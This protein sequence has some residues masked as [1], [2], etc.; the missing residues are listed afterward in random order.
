MFVGTTFEYMFRE[1]PNF[2]G[3]IE[4]WDVSS[5]VQMNHMFMDCPNFAQDLRLWEVGRVT[6][7][8]HMFVYVSLPKC[9]S[10]ATLILFKVSY[11]PSQQATSFNSDISSWDVAS[12]DTFTV[13]SLALDCIMRLMCSSDVLHHVSLIAFKHCS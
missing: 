4:S 12:A 7:F 8:Q 1:C 13:S 11:L 5:A 6:N 10:N 2:N 3:N 9:L